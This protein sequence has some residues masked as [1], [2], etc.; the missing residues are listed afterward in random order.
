[1]KLKIKAFMDALI[2]DEGHIV[3]SLVD[4][5]PFKYQDDTLEF[6]IEIKDIKKIDTTEEFRSVE[7]EAVK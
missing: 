3:N 6:I 7:I 2:H 4:I 5:L 1:M